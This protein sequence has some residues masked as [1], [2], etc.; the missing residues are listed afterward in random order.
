MKVYIFGIVEIKF[1]CNI[2]WFEFWSDLRVGSDWDN[3]GGKI[4]YVINSL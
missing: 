1:V 3:W 2:N 4:V